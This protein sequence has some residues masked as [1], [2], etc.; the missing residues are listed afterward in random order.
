MRLQSSPKKL[1]SNGSMLDSACP[2]ECPGGALPGF[3]TLPKVPPCP[4]AGDDVLLDG[5]SVAIV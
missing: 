1:P 5:K 2:R 4:Q 3:N